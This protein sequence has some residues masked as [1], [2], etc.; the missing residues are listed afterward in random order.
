MSRLLPVAFL[1]SGEGTTL[2]AMAELVAGGH[3]PIRIVL[4]TADRPHI[5]AIERARRYGLPTSVLPL[6][7]MSE[8]EWATQLD[9]Q[10]TD[11][12]AELVVLAG[13][14]AILPRVWLDRW[15]GRVINVHPSL[16]PKYGGRGYYGMRVHRAVLSARE[17]E[18]GVT[19]H[20]VT[21]EVDSGPVLLQERSPVESADTVES[22]RDR[23][24]P[25]EVRLLA[26]AIRRFAE[27]R[28]PLPYVPP[29]GERAEP[30][31]RRGAS[32]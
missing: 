8:A 31:G 3:L 6:R 12:G 24:H 7:G 13:F 10:L 19:V 28:W 22:L 1:V 4:V 15:M 30:R 14:L 27:G 18:T 11:R 5:A 17:R 25:V 16:L 32:G 26:E 2:E 23:L 9:A 21:P 29:P 20:L